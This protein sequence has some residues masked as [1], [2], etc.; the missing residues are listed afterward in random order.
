MVA[1]AAHKLAHTADV[2]EVVENRN[3]LEGANTGHKMT[4]A[5]A[6]AEALPIQY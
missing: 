6:G 5:V 2:V 4:G 3:G 1:A